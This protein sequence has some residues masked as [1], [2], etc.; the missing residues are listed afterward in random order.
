MIN[1]EINK[2]ENEEKISPSRQNAGRLKTENCTPTD[3]S[4]QDCWNIPKKTD[5]KEANMTE[6]YQND[7]QSKL[8]PGK[9][10]RR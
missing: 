3:L 5:L 9:M 7:W 2:A 10:Y 1:R 8:V 4:I 6:K